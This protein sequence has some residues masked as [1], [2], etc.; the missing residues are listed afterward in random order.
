MPA[1][2]LAASLV[3][4]SAQAAVLQLL[5][6]GQ[7]D[8]SVPVTSLQEARFKSTR[9]QQ[10]DFSCGSAAVS[11]LLTYHYAYPVSEKA[12]FED[13]YAVGNQEKIR[14][15]GFSLLDIKSYLGRHG[16]VADAFE[17]PLQKLADEG[18][19][20][21]VIV[22]DKGYH[23]FVVVKGL[24][25]GRVLLG[26]PSSGMRVATLEH[27]DAIWKRRLLFVIYNRKEQARFNS[28]ADWQLAP[29]APLAYGLDADAA[30][31][32]PWAKLGPTDY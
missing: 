15:E 5:G 10:Y 18:L 3:R 6:T 32:L 1:W 13:M 22:D 17:L 26:D 19:P 25:D 30:M 8:F 7:G 28:T 14:K 9:K 23:H 27:F 20:A 21:L 29:R 16:F 11:T 31:N 24:R 12:V 4:T 2:L